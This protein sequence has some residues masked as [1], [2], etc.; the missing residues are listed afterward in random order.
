MFKGDNHD[1]MERRHEKYI[2]CVN[3]ILNIYLGYV[4]VF[5]ACILNDNEMTSKMISVI[6]IIQYVTNNE[7]VIKIT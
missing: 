5:I 6:I 1:M 2:M 4:Q 7:R 3:L